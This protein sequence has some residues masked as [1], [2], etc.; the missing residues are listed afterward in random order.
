VPLLIYGNKRIGDSPVIYEYDEEH[1]T[2][3]NGY[4]EL[5]VEWDTPGYTIELKTASTSHNLLMS[6]PAQPTEVLPNS[7]SAITLYLD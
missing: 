7:L 3:A 6:M 5:I 4:V 1:V 2:D